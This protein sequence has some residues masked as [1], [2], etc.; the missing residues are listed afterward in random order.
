MG[1]KCPNQVYASKWKAINLHIGKA[2]VEETFRNLHWNFTSD[3]V[4]VKAKSNTESNAVPKVYDYSEM[5]IIL[6]RS[7]VTQ[8][9]NL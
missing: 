2:V 9:L 7:Q 8:K 4:H 3:T 1:K 6:M 5:Q